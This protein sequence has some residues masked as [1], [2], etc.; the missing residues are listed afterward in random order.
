MQLT[1]CT[2]AVVFLIALFASS[3]KSP[4]KITAEKEVTQ[5]RQQTDS[6][7]LRVEKTTRLVTVPQT[8]AKISLTPE[9]LQQLPVG[10][11]YQAKDGQATG[12]V[13]RTK[14]GFEFRA[15][16]DSLQFLVTDLRVEI[17]RL[18]K[19][20]NELK[21]QLKETKIVEVNKLTRWQKFR[22]DLANITIGILGVGA[23]IGGALLIRKIKKII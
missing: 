16:C 8:T 20:E 12:T 13:T 11:Q 1:K 7:S 6:V 22:I 19:V 2:L 18:K 15:N 21:T 4:T 17:D 3:C 9:D 5:S 23:L 10:G 14:D